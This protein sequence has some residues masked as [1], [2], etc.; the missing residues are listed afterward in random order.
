MSLIS[1]DLQG[2]MW[3]ATASDALRTELEWYEA[4][5][6]RWARQGA[7]AGEVERFTATTI[8][9]VLEHAQIGMVI[10]ASLA[11]ESKHSIARTAPLVEWIVEEVPTVSQIV[12][13]SGSCRAYARKLTKGAR[14]VTRLGLVVGVPIPL[15]DEPTPRIARA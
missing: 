1:H 15:P 12:S 2:L 6:P 7:T 3:I 5:I 13:I 10:E 8:P 4:Q 14:R 11:W 9:L